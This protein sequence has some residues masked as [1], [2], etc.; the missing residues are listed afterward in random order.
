MRALGYIR[1]STDE[2]AREGHSI[3]AQEARLRAWCEARGD[4][5]VGVVVD[6]GVSAGKPLDRRKGG[7]ELLARMAAGE[8]DVVVVIA[9]N[10]IFRDTTDGLDHLTGPRA[11]ALQSVGELIDTTTAQGRFILT[12]LLASAQ[13]EREQTCERNLA[14]ATHLRK[15]GKP[16]GYTPYGC[17]TLQ[18]ADGPKLFRDPDTWPIREQMVAARESGMT[19]QAIADTLTAEGIASPNGKPTWGKRTVS[20]VIDSHHGLQHLPPLPGPQETGVS[21]PAMLEGSDQ[22]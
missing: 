6:A 7:A 11:M 14:I 1:V 8:A 17:V 9:L 12:I 5:L 19:F 15:S 4:S 16:Y 22:P 2:Q 18:T 20:R 3:E 10:R 21:H 13:F